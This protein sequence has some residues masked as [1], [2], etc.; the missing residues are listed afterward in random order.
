MHRNAR[1]A[2]A[3]VAAGLCA[4][5]ATAVPAD[6]AGTF[7]SVSTSWGTAGWNPTTNQLR[8]TDQACDGFAV[9]AR[10]DWGGRSDTP[11]KL[12]DHNCYKTDGPITAT[13]QVPSGVKSINIQL[14]KYYK[15]KADLCPTQ[16]SESV[17]T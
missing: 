10:W 12:W 15:S 4:G 1:H 16:A 3:L 2:L 5:V 8:V 13:L 9:Y 6:A 7:Y 11:V 14:C 17:V